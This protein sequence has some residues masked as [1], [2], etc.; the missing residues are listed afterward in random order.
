VHLEWREVQKPWDSWDYTALLV[1]AAGPV[2]ALVSYFEVPLWGC[3][4]RWLTGWPCFSCGLT[5]ATLSLAAGRP[6]EALG[7]NPLGVFLEAA[8]GVAALW[9]FLS[10]RYSWRRP[11]VYLSSR[12][13]RRLWT[14]AVAVVLLNYAQVLSYHRP[15]E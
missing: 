1:A 8:V 6:W 4:F 10:R 15:W 7:Y 5:R 2:A 13:K 3:T 9:G 14:A 11:V 12:G